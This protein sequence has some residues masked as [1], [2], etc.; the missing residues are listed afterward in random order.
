MLFDYY[1]VF[2]KWLDEDDNEY[3]TNIFGK[4]SY[5]S[6]ETIT[7]PR[8]ILEEYSTLEKYKNSFVLYGEGIYNPKIKLIVQNHSPNINITYWDK[9]KIIVKV[10]Y[11]SA[12]KK[13]KSRLI[14]FS[15]GQRIVIN[16]SEGLHNIL[17]N[18]QK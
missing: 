3:K 10:D 17:K 4:V 5:E 13:D 1:Y 14:L 9:N 18:L 16:N 8:S 15:N 2:D 6:Y 12:D 11:F 7:I